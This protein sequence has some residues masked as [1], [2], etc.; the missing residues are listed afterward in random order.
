MG[1]IAFLF[2]GQGAQSIGMG[3]ELCEA[4]A[5]ARDIFRRANEILGY[6]L[7]EICFS[8][9]KEKLDATEHG[10]PALF[11]SSIAA[12]EYLKVH[13]PDVVDQCQFAAGLSLGEYTAMV[14]A[15]AIDFEAGLQLVRERGLAMQAAAGA[16]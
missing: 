13:Q 11:V 7:T 9:P 8:G 16:G 4:F 1:S 2:P 14:F 3:Q 10:Q 5:P 6:D 12:L 15:E